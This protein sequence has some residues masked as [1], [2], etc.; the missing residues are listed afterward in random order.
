MIYSI[1]II[2]FLKNNLYPSWAKTTNVKY[3]VM[4]PQIYHTELIWYISKYNLTP[5]SSSNDQIY[6]IFINPILS[7][8]LDSYMT[9]THLLFHVIE[10]KKCF[11]NLSY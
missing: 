9:Y 1:L 11:S 2:F 5:N 10:R 4:E 6:T 8:G 3:V 7:L